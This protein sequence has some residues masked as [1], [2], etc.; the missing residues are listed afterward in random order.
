VLNTFLSLLGISNIRTC[1]EFLSNF[2]SLK[3]LE[4]YF[5]KKV[6]FSQ[7]IAY[8]RRRGGTIVIDRRDGQI[9][10]SLL[11]SHAETS[12]SGTYTCNPSSAYARKVNVHVTTGKILFHQVSQQIHYQLIL[13]KGLLKKN[14]P[15]SEYNLELE[16]NHLLLV[17]AFHNQN[18]R[19]KR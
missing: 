14:Q 19:D 2:I 9:I 10:T 17:K 12:D 3:A 6:I 15:I 4:R 7:I 1:K 16:S 5:E 8:D 11:I 13:P 18:L